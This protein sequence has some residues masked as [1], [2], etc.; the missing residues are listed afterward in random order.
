MYASYSI[1]NAPGDIGF[2]GWQ[3]VASSVEG[4]VQGF[5]LV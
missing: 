3:L 2:E 5:D 1:I 4:H